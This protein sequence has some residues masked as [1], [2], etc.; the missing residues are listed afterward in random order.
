VSVSSS[1]VPPFGLAAGLSGPVRLSF[2]GSYGS[3]RECRVPRARTECVPFIDQINRA[4]SLALD[5]RVRDML[6]GL[7]ASF[8][9]RR[10]FIGRR[11][12]ST[13]FQLSV[14]GQFLFEAGNVLGQG[15]FPGM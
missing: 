9:D 13:Q 7:Q 6:V 10:S 11:T 3:E 4:L 8:T 1:F 2:I 5:T 15:G 12:G 14:F